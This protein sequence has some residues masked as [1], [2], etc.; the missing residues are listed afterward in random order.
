MKNFKLFDDP[1]H[2]S[3]KEIMALIGYI[4]AIAFVVIIVL[5]V[6]TP[7]T[8]TSVLT[9]SN[10]QEVIQISESECQRSLDELMAITQEKPV[11]KTQLTKNIVE[12]EILDEGHTI[13]NPTQNLPKYVMPDSACGQALSGYIK[14][15]VAGATR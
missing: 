8:P 4:F 3:N 10:K 6:M 7:S 12:Q 9:V 2:L 1:K 11:T 5:A 13:K 14:V 15:I